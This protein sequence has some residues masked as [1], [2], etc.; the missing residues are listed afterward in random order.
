MRVH[1]HCNGGLSPGFA[2][3][4][5]FLVGSHAVLDGCLIE[6][7]AAVESG[8]GV[9]ARNSSLILRAGTLIRANVVSVNGVGNSIFS[10]GSRM[11]SRCL[12][13]R[14]PRL[15]Q[16]LQCSHRCPKVRQRAMQE[17]PIQA[18]KI[19]ALR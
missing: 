4:Q 8:G 12:P 14:S 1:E 17:K 5:Y 13:M 18:S 19:A 15:L 10:A 2:E 16:L 6:D 7:N 9:D 3:V 11:G